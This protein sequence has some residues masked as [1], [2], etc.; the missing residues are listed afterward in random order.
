MP[1]PWS[2]HGTEVLTTDLALWWLYMLSMSGHRKMVAAGDMVKINHWDDVYLDAHR[3][4]GRRHRY[5]NC[6]D[7]PALDPFAAFVDPNAL[8]MDEFWVLPGQAQG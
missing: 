2:R 5:S 3:G 8:D 7:P 6:E 4:L 1:V